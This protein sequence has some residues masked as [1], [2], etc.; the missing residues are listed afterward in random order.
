MMMM[1][2]RTTV[3]MLMHHVPR[4]ATRPSPSLACT[5]FRRP[6]GRRILSWGR[7]VDVDADVDF[8]S[9]HPAASVSAAASV[10]VAVALFVA[11]C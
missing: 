2:M 7:R 10:A 6:I 8:D 9:L 4:L 11:A 1:R 5:L 3:T